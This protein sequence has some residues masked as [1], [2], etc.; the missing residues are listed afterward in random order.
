MS[1]KTI[2]IRQSR[3]PEADTM[4]AKIIRLLTSK[5]TPDSLEHISEFPRDKASGLKLVKSDN[6]TRI[7]T[8]VR[9][10]MS[11]MSAFACELREEK[12]FDEAIEIWQEL[13]QADQMDENHVLMLLVPTLVEVNRLNEAEYL[14]N[15]Y[16]V[17]VSAHM[18]YSRAICMFKKHGQSR[19]ADDALMNAIWANKHVMEIFRGKRKISNY[20]ESFIFGSPDEAMH[21]LMFAMEDWFHYDGLAEWIYRFPHRK[22]QEWKLDDL[23]PG[24]IGDN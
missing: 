2:R 15:R 9:P 7:A 18:M 19:I 1:K 6:M 5:L 23:F 21:Y 10:P 20:K 14:L 17:D 22:V 4:S 24:L 16:Y 13:L 8:P 11:E 3:A 12:R